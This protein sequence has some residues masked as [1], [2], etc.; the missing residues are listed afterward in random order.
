MT[1]RINTTAMEAES[2]PWMP[3]ASFTVQAEVASAQTTVTVELRARLDA[4]AP[5]AIAG[6]F[7]P[8][9]DPFLF[10]LAPL[11]E[12]KLVVHGNRAGDPVKVWSVE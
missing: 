2:P 3:Q 12:V 6:A 1:E 11:G 5:W 10:C 8:A 9:S 7:R 4:A